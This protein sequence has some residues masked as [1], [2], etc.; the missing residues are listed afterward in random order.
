ELLERV[1]PVHRFDH[2]VALGLEH[3]GH[4]GS[5]VV[6]VLHDQHVISP[7]EPAS[8]V[9]RRGYARSGPSRSPL[10][11]S[12]VA[13]GP[14]EDRGSDTVNVA[15]RPTPSLATVMVPPCSSTRWRVI[16]RPRP[17]PP[18]SRPVTGSACWNRS[19]TNGRKSEAMPLPVSWTTSSARDPTC[20]TR[21]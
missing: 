2:R 11:A 4:D 5:D 19:K 13:G 3:R 7:H 18:C 6:I 21:A 8:A 15:P 20:P 14:D 17:S 12:V 10:R 16:A 1:A 9:A